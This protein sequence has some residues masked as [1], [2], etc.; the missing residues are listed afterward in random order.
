VK[1][2]TSREEAED[3]FLDHLRSIEQ[4]I[5]FVSDRAS[6]RDAEAEDFASY[7]KLRLIDNDYAILRKF[8]GRCSLSRFISIVIN[9]FLLDYRIH[10]WG[11]WHASAEA[12]HLGPVA[13]EFE[14]L[15]SRDGRTIAEALAV[16]QSLDPSV[17]ARTLEDIAARL[18]KRLSRARPVDIDYVD[19][20]LHVPADS[21]YE[22]A[23][24]TERAAL[25]K[26]ASDV[27]RAVLDDFP[28]DDQVFL[29]LHFGAE[30]TIAEVARAMGT[31]QKPLYRRLKRCLREFRR[32]L[33]ASGITAEGVEEI[34][35]CRTSDLDFGLQA[36]K[37]RRAS[38]DLHRLRRRNGG[39]PD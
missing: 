7:V 15:V 39:G 14:K 26:N 21:I 19:H 2:R 1:I 6:Q 32:R 31:Q 34:L 20:E 27:V 12:K 24:D 10:S 18:P 11:K 37:S 22:D 16:C 9:R 30:M 33:E 25:S 8:E 35:S 23:L 17:T 38:V 28:Q 5:R 3:L 36:R 4:V 13:V 29:R